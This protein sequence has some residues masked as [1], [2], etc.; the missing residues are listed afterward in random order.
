MAAALGVIA[1]GAEDRVGIYPF[2][3]RLATPFRPLRGRRNAHRLFGWL[4]AL[5]IGEQTDLEA[6]LRS[7][8][9]AA[10]RRGMV[11]LI[12]DLLD[13]E[14]YDE[15]LRWLGGGSRDAF[16]IHLLSPQ[17]IDPPLTGDLRLVDVEDGSRAD[18]SINRAILSA[19]R[20]TVEG[21]RA[22]VREAC[23]RR[24]IVPL[25]ASTGTPFDRLVLGTLRARRLIE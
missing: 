5:E 12:S 9:A 13:P 8:R 3:A 19:Y 7:F 20:R 21:F 18:V 24:G 10:P 16:L 22:G 4:G 23:T 17:E 14:G 6:S 1:L 2:D 11:I 25:T 15:P